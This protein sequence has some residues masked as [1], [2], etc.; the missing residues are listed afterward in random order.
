VKEA[1]DSAVSLSAMRVVAALAVGCVVK[2]PVTANVRTAPG[3]NAVAAEGVTAKDVSV[4]G[5][6][7]VMRQEAGERVTGGE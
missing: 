4:P 3:M 1:G 7:V 5:A 6:K 2:L